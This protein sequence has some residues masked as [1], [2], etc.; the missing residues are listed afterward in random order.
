MAARWARAGGDPRAARSARSPHPAARRPGRRP[1]LDRVAYRQRNVIERAVGW[2]QERRRIA[3]R[4]AKLAIQYLALLYVA[5]PEKYLT[6]LFA[7][8][9]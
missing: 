1:Q 4:Y 8:T 3:T 9:A 6:T 2:L 7:N 5:L